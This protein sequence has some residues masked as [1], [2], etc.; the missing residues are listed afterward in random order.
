[1]KKSKGW[2]GERG[3]DVWTSYV[4][5]ANP[6][7]PGPAPLCD[8]PS[9]NSQPWLSP[10]HQEWGPWPCKFPLTTFFWFFWVWF[11][12]VHSMPQCRK[13]SH[14]SSCG[15]N[16]SCAC[17]YHLDGI[18]S[19]PTDFKWVSIVET[20][21]TIWFEHTKASGSHKR[22]I[23]DHINISMASAFICNAC[24]ARCMT[25]D[26][27]T[28]NQRLFTSM[29]GHEIYLGVKMPTSRNFC[30]GSAWKCLGF[31]VGA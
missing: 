1:M 30:L 12:I 6:T 27:R 20:P 9:C 31:R 17:W 14:G 28:S 4:L 23:A 13:G 7:K 21:L 25:R 18:L 16:A 26:G 5:P 22:F 8:H 19:N 24:R 10:C 3:V 2:E 15:H 11:S 29:L